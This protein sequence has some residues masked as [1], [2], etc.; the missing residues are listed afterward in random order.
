M[1]CNSIKVV[2]TGEFF[3]SYYFESKSELSNSS[4]VYFVLSLIAHRIEVNQDE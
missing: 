2:D 4:E 1:I 3:I